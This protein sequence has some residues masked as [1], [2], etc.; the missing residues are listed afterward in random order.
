MPIQRVLIVDDDPL[1]REF[2]VEAV[3]SL[4]FTV[5]K[6]A[7]GKEALAMIANRVPDLVL[8]DLRMPEMS[9]LEV[10]DRAK[11]IDPDLAIV[12]VTAL[13]EVNTAIDA[14]RSERRPTQGGHAPEVDGAVEPVSFER[15][16]ETYEVRRAVDRLGDAERQVVEL[17][18]RL[19]LTHEQIADR[20][21][22]PIGTVKSRLHRAHRRL[23]AALGYLRDDTENHPAA[24]NVETGERP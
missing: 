20:L 14:M 7:S 6:A 11:V 22:L 23:A 16:W 3:G 21:D 10:V 12:I 1:S 5:D 19:G 18:H 17:N 4:G 15:T 13:V 9:G 24:R 2:L 8:S